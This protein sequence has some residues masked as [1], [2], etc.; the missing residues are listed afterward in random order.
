MTYSFKTP[1]GWFRT[2]HKDLY[3][4]DRA[5]NIGRTIQDRSFDAFESDYFELQTEL[6]DWFA[7][8]LPEVM[9]RG[10]LHSEYSGI[11]LGPDYIVADLDEKSLSIFRD[12]WNDTEAGWTVVDHLSYAQ[13][14][15]HIQSCK[16]ISAPMERRSWWYRLFNLAKVFGDHRQQ[17][18]V[19]W[20]DT[21]L[22]VLLVGVARNAKLPSCDDAWWLLQQHHS[23]MQNYRID[24]F[25][26]GVFF[27]KK[28]GQKMG[29][30]FDWVDETAESWNGAQ[31][32]EDLLRMNRLRETLGISEHCDVE[33]NNG[34]Y[35]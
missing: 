11:M 30:E 20:W 2:H 33:I 27:P 7:K 22:G 18:L 12:A 35:I 9:I 25:P 13:W 6:Y 24:D 19:R 16:V 26:H 14:L 4:L 5:C 17:Q 23:E 29:I 15:A 28:I 21:D 32:A 3:V 34:E 1:E 31:Y 8:H 10:I